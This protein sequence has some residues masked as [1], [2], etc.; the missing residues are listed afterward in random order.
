MSGLCEKISEN[1]Y[2]EMCA[3]VVGAKS[4]VAACG[5]HTQRA[6][7]FLQHTATW[8][9]RLNWANLVLPAKAENVAVARA[10][11]TG[12]IAAR[13]EDSWDVTLELLEELKVAVSEAVSN[14]I[15]HA[16]G[17]D[18]TRELEIFVEQYEFALSVCVAD[19]G[20]GIADVA[21]AREPDFTTG[22]EHLGLGFAFMETFT[23]IMQVDSELG[24]G[25]KVTLVKLLSPPHGRTNAN[26]C[27]C[28]A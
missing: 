27:D 22:D 18:A 17:K 24:L 2:G 4:E 20:V 6:T 25:T 26:D 10:F 23:D 12:L 13:E 19:D 8:G 16:Y 21:R 3:N 9:K 11:L 15:I 28:G 14:A 5:L 7:A 1:I